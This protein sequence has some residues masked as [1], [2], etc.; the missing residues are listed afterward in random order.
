[1]YIYKN[2]A[3]AARCPAELCGCGD[4]LDLDELR[5]QRMPHVMQSAG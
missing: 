1:M 3:V 2:V 4:D 5:A